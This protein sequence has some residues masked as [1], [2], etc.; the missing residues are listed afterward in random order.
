MS[1]DSYKDSHGTAMGETPTDADGIAEIR[2]IVSFVVAAH[3]EMPAR[4][5]LVLAAEVLDIRDRRAR[6]YYHGEV[7]ALRAGEVER[8]RD[9][10]GRWLRVHVRGLARELMDLTGMMA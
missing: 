8:V 7:R 4:R 1:K 10:Y 3:G 9:A 5:A 6:A 2:R